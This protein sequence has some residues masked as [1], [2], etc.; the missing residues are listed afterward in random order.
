MTRL[1][2]AGV[3][4]AADIGP[5][6]QAL[7]A[8]LTLRSLVVMAEQY[9]IVDHTAAVRLADGLDHPEDREARRG[10]LLELARHT[11]QWLE[12]PKGEAEVRALRDAFTPWLPDELWDRIVQSAEVAGREVH[13]LEDQQ[14]RYIAEADLEFLLGLAVAP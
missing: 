14:A 13:D 2:H 12:D 9:S 5:E 4:A 8:D 1:I 7:A 10:A 3:R 11:P 6:A